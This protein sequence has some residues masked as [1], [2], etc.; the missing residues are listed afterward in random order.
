MAQQRNCGIRAQHGNNHGQRDEAQI[1]LVGNTIINPKHG[2][3]PS[4]T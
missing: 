2:D 3:Q 1:V 4:P